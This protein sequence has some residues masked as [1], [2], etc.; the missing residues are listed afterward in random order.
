MDIKI[1][2]DV[3]LQIDNALNSNVNVADKS[4]NLKKELKYEIHE[5]VSQLR[6]LLFTLK[7]NLQE[8]KNET[9]LTLGF[10]QL[11]V[12]L[13]EKEKSSTQPRQVA[14]PSSRHTELTNRGTEASAPPSC[15]RKKLFSEIVG[16]KYE[17]RHKLTI[18]PKLNESSEEIQKL[19]KT[20][21]ISIYMIIVIRNFKSLRNGKILIETDGKGELEILNSQI[22]DKC[23][24]QLEI[25]IHKRKN[26]RLIIYNVPETLTT[27]NAEGIIMA[28]YPN[29]KL[30]EGN[31]QTEYSFKTW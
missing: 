14:T 19:L 13:L 17:E 9:K 12:A 24:S 3:S 7:W 4:G 16:A 2:E 18:K 29:L 15:N 23:G 5:S 27:E 20:K 1:A 28:H 8:T 30:Q 6:K 26:P 21:F 22:H 25:N 31:I 10:K 11:N